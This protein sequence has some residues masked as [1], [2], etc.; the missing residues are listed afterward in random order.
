MNDEN[1]EGVLLRG[2]GGASYFIPQSELAHFAIP[3][4]L[5]PDESVTENAPHIDAF[6]VRGEPVESDDVKAFHIIGFEAESSSE[7]IGVE[8]EDDADDSAQIIGGE[9]EPG[10]DDE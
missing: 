5:D 1:T 3:P 8:G 2:A 10:G 9:D 6:R 7:I 4:K